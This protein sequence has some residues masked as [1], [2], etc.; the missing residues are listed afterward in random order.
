M[1]RATG[2]SISLSEEFTHVNIV[3]EE[4]EN[5]S[6]EEITTTEQEAR[7]V[8]NPTTNLHFSQQRTSLEAEPVEY[9]HKEQIEAL[10]KKL[11]S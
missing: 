11:H 10:N 7:D 5:S 6:G 8:N 2:N 4:S 1:C 9:M 3:L